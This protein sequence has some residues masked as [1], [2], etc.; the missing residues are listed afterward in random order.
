MIEHIEEI[1]KIYF[2]LGI[3]RST[4]EHG[5]TNY[6]FLFFNVNSLLP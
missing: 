1:K 5:I 4:E 6:R 2:H 3:Y